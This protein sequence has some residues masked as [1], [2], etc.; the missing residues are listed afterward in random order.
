M[1]FICLQY[2]ELKLRILWCISSILHTLCRYCSQSFCLSV[3]DSDLPSAVHCCVIYLDPAVQPRLFKFT[4][5]VP[6]TD[7]SLD[8]VTA[9]FYDA[10]LLYFGWP[11]AAYAVLAIL[12]LLMFVFPL[13]FFFLFY[14]LAIFQRCF[15]LCK[16]DRPG[17]RALVDSYQGCFKNSA[18]D[19]V[20]RRYFA[21]IYL[22]VRLYIIIFLVG[23]YVSPVYQSKLSFSPIL[24]VEITL[25]LFMA[26]LISLFR[27]Y[28]KLAHN[29]VDFMLFF[30]MGLLALISNT[31]VFGGYFAVYLPI[32]VLIIYLLIKIIIFCCVRCNCKRKKSLIASDHRQLL[33]ANTVQ[34]DQNDPSHIHVV[35]KTELLLSSYVADE[36]Y[37]D[38]VVNP[39]GYNEQHTH[40]ISV[41]ED[42][43]LI[44]EQES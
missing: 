8:R 13:I 2:L 32:T 9:F 14:H 24:L 25:C 41:D 33:E 31:S 20:E 43:K 40:Y 28:K 42:T 21:G 10:N 23:I 18:R 3:C 26:G 7:T 5:V 30:Y 37:P 29:A 38:R 27:P 22:L 12:C 1:G 6:T 15:S 39:S 44:N 11:H 34:K 17:L 4:I 16:L 35:T 36:E 19:G